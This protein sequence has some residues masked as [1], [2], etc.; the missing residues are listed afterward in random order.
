MKG[1]LIGAILLC[2]AFG[3]ANAS[4]I[5]VGDFV[6]A[7]ASYGPIVLDSNAPGNQVSLGNI[8][9]GSV[10]QS[11]VPVS[12]MFAEVFE[13]APTGAFNTLSAS[14]V[15]SG[16]NDITEAVL[17]ILDSAG[18]VLKLID[19]AIGGTTALLSYATDGSNFNVALVGLIDDVNFPQADYSLNISAVPVPAAVWLFGTA[20][21]GLLGF[22]KKASMAVAAA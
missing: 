11:G 18:Q 20:L 8:A 21:F 6:T 7:T 22:R 4:L 3:T 19:V 13:I 1:K 17:A 12:G 15:I 9:G 14:V 10:D 2:F 16:T 5:A